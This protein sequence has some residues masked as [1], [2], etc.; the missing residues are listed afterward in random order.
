MGIFWGK[1]KQEQKQETIQQQPYDSYTQQEI[2]EG[3]LELVQILMDIVINDVSNNSFMDDFL[4]NSGNAK[5][6]Y[7]EQEEV[8][9]HLLDISQTM[10][11]DAENILEYHQK[12][13]ENLQNIFEKIESIQHSVD[14]VA[15]GNKQY[16]QECSVL[17]HNI[18]SINQFT[19]RIHTISS[20]TNLLALNASIEAA[21]AGAAGKGFAVVAREV[22][23]LSTNT[24]ETSNQIDKAIGELTGQVEE[25]VKS[26]QENTKRLDELYH[27]IGESFSL[28]ESIKE[29][30]QLNS[31]KTQAMLSSITQNIQSINRVTKFN[32]MIQELDEEDK[33]RVKKVVSEL[34]E[35]VV[36]SNDLMSFLVQ[37]REIFLYLQQK[38][39]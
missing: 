31:E 15:E 9:H 14:N 29:L 7:E 30:N 5:Q 11:Q 28:F 20:Q 35:N 36:L 10:N 3:G 12:D 19:S 27:I 33:K 39:S 32:D 2:I 18:K 17:E 34:S 22:K 23:E 26:I 4:K 13:I 8:V 24:Q 6:M 1:K 21:R 38:K 16:I 25:F 37:I